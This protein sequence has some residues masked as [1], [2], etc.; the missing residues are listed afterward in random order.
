MNRIYRLVW[1]R[2]L[3]ALV[4]AP[5]IARRKGKTKAEAQVATVGAVMFAF[6]QAMVG[7]S[8]SLPAEAAQLCLTDGTNSNRVGASPQNKS[9]LQGNC[10]QLGGG[11]NS[12][13][14]DMALLEADGS[15]FWVDGNVDT[16]NFRPG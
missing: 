5:E 16:I 8:F 12:L 7:L 11:L 15:A 6:S 14:H 2:T 1:N 9:S 10:G 3:G 13:R 4:A